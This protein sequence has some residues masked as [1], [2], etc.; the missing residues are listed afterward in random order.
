ML[1]TYA[2]SSNS[3]VPA[4]AAR[5]AP[6]TREPRRG[7][8]LLT[9]HDGLPVWLRSGIGLGYA[10]TGAAHLV[11]GALIGAGEKP[12]VLASVFV[13][14]LVNILTLDIWRARLIAWWRASARS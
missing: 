8:A 2:V 3:A 1:D 4:D 11:V 12:L 6:A 9:P 7:A 5:T 10:A 13:L 14:L